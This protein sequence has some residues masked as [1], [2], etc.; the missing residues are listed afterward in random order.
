[1]Q[2]DSDEE[3]NENQPVQTKQEKNGNFRSSL[4]PAF[5]EPKKGAQQRHPKF[6][7]KPS[8]LLDLRI[9]LV[10]YRTP[11]RKINSVVFSSNNFVHVAD[12]KHCT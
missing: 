10:Y 1:M 2:H 8:N 7:P 5:A 4:R 9:G 12:L 6:P 3:D 11:Q